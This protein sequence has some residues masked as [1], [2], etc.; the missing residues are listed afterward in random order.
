[1][2]PGQTKYNTILFDREHLAKKGVHTKHIIINNIEN[3]YYY[4]YF[5]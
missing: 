3:Y 5:F 4:V 1:M 2:P